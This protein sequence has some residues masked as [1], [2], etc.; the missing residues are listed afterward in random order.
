MNYLLLVQ[1]REPVQNLLDINSNERF[2]E[3]AKTGH[4][5]LERPFRDYLENEINLVVTM[6]LH[7]K[8]FHNIWMVQR[9]QHADLILDLTYLRPSNHLLNFFAQ[10]YRFYSKKAAFLRVKSLVNLSTGSRS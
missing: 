6:R 1:V 8:I 10:F 5:L 7:F 3:N 9:C 2:F 4:D